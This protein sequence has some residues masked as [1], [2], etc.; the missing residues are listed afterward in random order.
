MKVDA[1]HVD[2]WL[3]DKTVSALTAALACHCARNLMTLDPGEAGRFQIPMQPDYS[4]DNLINDMK[5]L[6]MGNGSDLH[7]AHTP[8]MLEIPGGNS[9]PALL[10][11]V[12]FKGSTLRSRYLYRGIFDLVQGD[13]LLERSAFPASLLATLI[14]ESGDGLRRTISAEGAITS[15]RLTLADLADIPQLDYNPEIISI[16]GDPAGGR[17]VRAAFTRQDENAWPAL[18]AKLMAISEERMETG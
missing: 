11:S 8:G 9:K 7:L 3:A 18:H 17:Q 5:S 2:A 4:A 6:L 16:T 14:A 15:K 1:P 13:I 10:H 12:K